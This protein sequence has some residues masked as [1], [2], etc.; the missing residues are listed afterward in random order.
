LEQQINI[1]YQNELSKFLRE[2]KI[3]D[4]KLLSYLREL[5]NGNKSI[6]GNETKVF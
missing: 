2:K 1:N 5:K 4:P 6:G 3:D